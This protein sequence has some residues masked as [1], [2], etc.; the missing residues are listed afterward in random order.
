M[1]MTIRMAAIA[2]A[3]VTLVGGGAATA[4]ASPAHPPKAGCDTGAWFG[5]E[6]T[7]VDGH[8][9]AIADLNGR[10]VATSHPSQGF[11]GTANECFFW[12]AAA[13]GSNNAKFAVVA[14]PQTGAPGTEALSAMWS[15]K[16]W[17]LGLSAAD[18]ASTA[19]EWVFDGADFDNAASGLKFRTT[20]N[21]GPVAL[22][23]AATPTGPSDTFTPSGF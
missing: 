2:A 23:S 3:T 12:F 9:L 19:Q 10:I 22:V 1:R 11:F 4:M 20:S 16:G 21:G 14:S 13:T 8:G 7:Q 18:H 5:Y 15:P 17:V 6:G